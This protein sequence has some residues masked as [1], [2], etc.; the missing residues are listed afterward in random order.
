MT[1]A[2]VPVLAAIL[3]LGHVS[4]LR[5]QAA[6]DRFR[7]EA[8]V[9]WERYA[10]RLQ[11]LQGKIVQKDNASLVLAG[12]TY[13]NVHTDTV[14]TLKRAD[15]CYLIVQEATR[16][17]GGRKGMVRATNPK[18]AFKLR[19]KDGNGWLL[20]KTQMAGG[21]VRE[22]TEQPR[23]WVEW[24]TSAPVSVYYGHA[25]L[26]EFVKRPT[27]RLVSATARPDGTVEVVFRN[28]HPLP[29]DGIDPIQGGTMVLDPGHS[30]CLKSFRFDCEDGSGRFF[31]RSEFAYREPLGEFPLL[32]H[33]EIRG[34][35]VPGGPERIAWT[36]AADHDLEEPASPPPVTDFTLSAFGLPETAG[37]ARK[38]P[39]PMHLWILLGADACGVLALLLRFL[40]KR[41]TTQAEGRPA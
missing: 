41:R 19:S 33:S 7:D 3:L 14:F 2:L 27:F 29:K 17:D 30:W 12:K 26:P 28:P 6:A 36:A 22:P 18:Y 39:T 4:A 23:D 15:G 40:A 1:H 16:N 25:L 10:Q 13:P 5:A 20:E 9:A 35:P 38:K 37:I 11:R 24:K 8:P 21:S 31:L 34:G 32:A